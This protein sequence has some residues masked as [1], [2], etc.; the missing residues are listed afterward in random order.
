MNIKQTILCSVVLTTL[1]SGA[2]YLQA[3]SSITRL[4]PPSALFSSGDN[5]APYISRFIKGQRFDLQATVQPD[6]GLTV[7]SVEFKVDGKTVY[8]PYNPNDSRFA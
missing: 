1:V 8:E 6:A 4:T 3:A 2:S 5:G 7:T